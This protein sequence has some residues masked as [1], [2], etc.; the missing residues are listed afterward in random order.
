MFLAIKEVKYGFCDSHDVVEDTLWCGQGRMKHASFLHI[1]T[2]QMYGHGVIAARV[3][4]LI[5]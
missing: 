5:F 4:T 1:T 2:G 3:Q